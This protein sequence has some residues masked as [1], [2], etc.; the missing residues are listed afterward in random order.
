LYRTITAL[1]GPGDQRHHHLL[2]AIRLPLA[3]SHHCRDES[4]VA[5]LDGLDPQRAEADAQPGALV[6]PGWTVDYEAVVLDAYR[7]RDTET[8]A[9]ADERALRLSYIYALPCIPSTSAVFI[10]WA[11]H[12][13]GTLLVITSGASRSAGIGIGRAI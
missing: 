4:V 3:I 10:S 1:L 11:S 2:E 12:R 6:E 7:A 13:E 8:T 5:G 9:R